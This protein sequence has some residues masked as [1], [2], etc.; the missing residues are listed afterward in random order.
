MPR[1]L[2]T[3]AAAAMVA[4]ATVGTPTDADARSRRHRSGVPIGAVIGGLAAGALIGTALAAP[5]YYGAY[6]YEPVYFGQRCYVRRERIWNGRR[7]RIRQ[8]EECY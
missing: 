4:I 2:T 5:H 1:R 6:A 3:L 7:W 8:V